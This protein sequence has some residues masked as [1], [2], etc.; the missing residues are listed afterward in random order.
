MSV[1]PIPAA[2]LRPL[3][4]MIVDDSAVV[5]GL[6]SRWLEQERD[7]VLAG[8][9]IDGQKAIDKVREVQPDVLILDIEMPNM[10]GLEALPKLI[11]AKPGLKVLMASTLTTR[12][13]NV[14]LRALELGA[15]D[16]IPKPDSTRIG[17][18]DGFRTELL[19]KIRAL[20]GRTRQW[21]MP[22]ATPAPAPTP[23]HPT[24]SAFLPAARDAE[25]RPQIV[26][27]A[28]KPVVPA[29]PTVR[30]R[31]GPKRIDLLVVGA[32]TGGPPALRTFLLGLGPDWKLPILIVQHMPATFT[33]IL[34]EHLDK[35]LPQKVQEA[36]DG[37]LIE[38]R[39]VYIAPGDWHMTIR[40]DPIVKQIR[41]DQGPQVNWCRPAVDPLF[42]SAAEVYGNHALG[43]VLTGMGHDG[44]DGAQ[45]LVNV[46]GTVMV[47]DEASSVVW[48]MPG[49]VAEAG[50]AE[51]I[52]PI[53]GLSAACKAFARGERP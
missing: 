34:A 42:K 23:T 32:S 43:V 47:Q 16:Y 24:P 21:P 38:S 8:L 9:A 19:T 49:A 26:P 1:N 22:G 3:K 29:A 7:M 45:A 33:A 52:K 37:M 53:E 40:P 41:L 30:P 28:P 27:I 5:R 39:N 48:G 6:I 35:A 2:S 11:A 4:I 14:T 15:A 46:N 25:A 13:A 12:G 10:G 36:K 44:R 18:A 51:I 17:G 50:L 20:C 31:S